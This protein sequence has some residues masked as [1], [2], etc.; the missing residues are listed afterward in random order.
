MQIFTPC[1]KDISI[2]K[3]IANNIVNPLEIIRE[4]VSNSHDAEAKQISI[5]I[6]RN[7]EGKFILEI[8]DDGKGLDFNT[9]QAF[10]NLGDSKVPS[11]LGRKA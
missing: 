8:Q 2:F 10:F 11:E 7:S 6:S 5:I 9:L 4:G 1:V 3:E